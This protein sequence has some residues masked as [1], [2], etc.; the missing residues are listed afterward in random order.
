MMP[1]SQAT[2]ETD[3]DNKLSFLLDLDGTLVD[4]VYRHVLAW[5]E[6]FRN[7]DLNLSG[8][9]IHRRIGMSGS[10]LVRALLRAGGREAKEEEVQHLEQL[11]GEAY[12]RLVSE[13]EP[14]PGAKELLAEL[15]RLQVKWAIVTSSQPEKAQALLKKLGLDANATV[16]TRGEVDRAK[17]EPD[18]FLVGAKRLGVEVRDCAVVGDSVWDLLAAQRARALCVGLLTGGY[19]REELE[20]AGA[21]RVY[22]DC[23]NLLINLDELGIKRS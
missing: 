14:L 23:A 6:A 11:H 12:E 18:P 20:R 16:I 5:Q 1:R 3:T 4:S 22:D 2:D 7:V 9:R 10:L 13:V 19:G 8:W 15:S 21:Y 17:P